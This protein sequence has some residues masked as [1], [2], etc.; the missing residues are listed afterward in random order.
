MRN[1]QECQAE[2]F[3][4]SKI[5]IRRRRQR[6]L[7]TCIPLALCVVL[8]TAALWPSEERAKNA[9]LVG[10]LTLEAA[11]GSEYSLSEIRVSGSGVALCHTEPEIGQKILEILESS[12][13]YQTYSYT[14][15]EPEVAPET[16]GEVYDGI[17]IDRHWIDSG[18]GAD[19]NNAGATMAPPETEA[20]VYTLTL[21]YRDGS[22]ESYILT[23]GQL[24]DSTTGQARYLTPEDAT[25]LQTLLQLPE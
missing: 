19:G 12:A 21:V 15:D 5:R 25:A 6:V 13:N 22:I 10:G 16:Y 4:R 20:P 8:G 3:R 14:N 1:L 7:A 2:I 23:E 17:N 9:A 11:T 24:K 18:M